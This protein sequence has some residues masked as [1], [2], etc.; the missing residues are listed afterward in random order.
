MI[1]GQRGSIDT[2]LTVSHTSPVVMAA[3]EH[4]TKDGG[5][6]V[7]GVTIIAEFVR[8]GGG[9]RAGVVRAR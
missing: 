7:I 9:E 5:V 6:S 1:Q 4:V 8:G 3:V 2:L